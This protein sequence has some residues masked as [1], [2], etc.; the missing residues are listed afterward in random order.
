MIGSVWRALWAGWLWLWDRLDPAGRVV[1]EDLGHRRGPRLLRF[2]RMSPARAR[3]ELLRLAPRWE[4]V[5]AVA[6]DR[7]GLRL[8]DRIGIPRLWEALHLLLLGATGSGKTQILRALVEQIL[9][10]RTDLMLIIDRKGD[11]TAW[12]GGRADVAIL[13]PW[14]Q[15]TRSWAVGIDVADALGAAALAEHLVPLDTQAHDR[16]WVDT[17]RNIIRAAIGVLQALHGPRTRLDRWWGWADLAQALGQERSQ[18]AA[19]LAQTEEGARAAQAL[20]GNERVS[21]QDVYDSLGTW[22]RRLGH[23]ALG[24]PQRTGLS[25]RAW[26]RGLTGSRVLVVPTVVP[27]EELAATVVRLIVETIA[28]ELLVLPDDPARRIWLVL[29][30][31]NLTRLDTLTRLLPLARSKGGAVLA[32]LQDVARTRALYG[33]D[34]STSILNSFAV[35]TTLRLA[36]PDTQEWAAKALGRHDIERHRQVRSHHHGASSSETIAEQ[37]VERTEYLVLPDELGELPPLTG[38]LDIP[39]WPALYLRWP[40]APM[41]QTVAPWVPAAWV[42]AAPALCAQPHGGPQMPEGSHQPQRRQGL[43]PPGGH[44]GRRG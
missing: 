18:L 44:H 37:V 2:L 5:I 38:Y 43:R 3:R 20:L 23:I 17:P 27:D 22:T 8:W 12:L 7:P 33:R 34:F 39:Q 31:F 41:P 16:Y 14:D 42:K 24:W 19:W 11:F 21:A 26:T 32:A 29:D 15:R 10:D 6:G 36:D 13:A 35:R 40:Y 30:E 9:T 28:S 25:L 4:R 1:V